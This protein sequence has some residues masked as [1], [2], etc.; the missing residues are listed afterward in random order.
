M[1]VRSNIFFQ[2]VEKLEKLELSLSKQH[3]KILKTRSEILK[4][5]KN[6]KMIKLG[7]IFRKIVLAFSRIPGIQ[8]NLDPGNFSG[9]RETLHAAIPGKLKI[10]EKGKHYIVPTLDK[11]SL[12]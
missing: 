8:R 11:R 6:V 7:K 3:S 1:L 4:I 9:F 12:I 5:I 2:F 10:R